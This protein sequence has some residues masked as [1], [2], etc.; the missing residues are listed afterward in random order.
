MPTGTQQTIE[1]LLCEICRR[2][3]E[4]SS[5]INDL[6][7]MGC[8]EQYITYCASCGDCYINSEEVDSSIC[9]RGNSIGIYSV[10]FLS[11]L[12]TDEYVCIDCLYCCDNCGQRYQYEDGM[13]EC[14]SIGSDAIHGYSYRP[15]F[16]YYEI[17]DDVIVPKFCASPGVLYMGA[18][19]E[20]NKMSEMVDDFI[21]FC[22]AEQSEFVYFKEDGSLG[23]EGVEL[24]T[25]PATLEAFEQSFPF[26]ALDDAREKGARSFYYANC[27]FHIHVSRSAFTPSHMWKFIRF[28]LNNPY[29]C[30]RVAQRDESSYASWHFDDVEKRSLPEYVKGTKSNGRRYLAINFQNY[31]T[32]ELRYFKGNIL[33]SAIMKNLEFVQSI[34]D[35]TKVMN[36]RQVFEGA[37]SEQKYMLWLAD[38]HKYPNL[39]NFLNNGDEGEN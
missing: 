12:D 2:I 20:I 24:V 17:D 39:V 34:Y 5:E 35:Y 32:V 8:E 13:L 29:L 23:P 22:T 4:E 19:I 14:C 31:S 26:L 10:R 28:Q 1:G 11:A 38:Q 21:D 3:L 25:M 36:V 9:W 6:M 33:R 27:G 16:Y 18:E 15:T 37:L 7:C 30:Q